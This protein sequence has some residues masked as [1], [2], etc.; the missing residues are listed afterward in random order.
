M[1]ECAGIGVGGDPVGW[2]RGERRGALGYRLG[3]RPLQRGAAFHLLHLAA[4]ADS[5]PCC[6][7]ARR[8]ESHTYMEVSNGAQR[9]APSVLGRDG[10]HCDTVLR[11]TGCTACLSSAT[12]EGV[13]GRGLL[14]AEHTACEICLA[15]CGSCHWPGLLVGTCLG[16]AR[17]LVCGCFVDLSIDC[18]PLLWRNLSQSLS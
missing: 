8:G 3:Y 15:D 2:S 4:A 13:L 11:V 12:H 14:S 18:L 17:A 5:C 16:P 1:G 7:R 9:C 10:V 6:S